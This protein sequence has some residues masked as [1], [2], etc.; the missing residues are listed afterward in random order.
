MTH[1]IPR[2]L[3]KH[4]EWTP[5]QEPTTHSQSVPIMTPFQ[6]ISQYSIDDILKGK[7]FFSEEKDGAKYIGLPIALTQALEYATFDGIVATMP[8]LISAKI[9]AD[10]S[11]DFWQKWYSVHTEENIGIDKKGLF[12][13]KNEPVLV[14]VNGGGI[15]TPERIKQAYTEGL[16]DNSAKYTDTEFNDLLEGKL[17]SGITIP[18]YNFEDIKTGKS[19]LPHQ[20]GVVMPYSIA[21]GTSSGY[22]QKEAFL[23]NPLVIAR[24][25]GVLDQL[26]AY[27]KLAK[28][29]D[30]DLGNYHPFSG[31]DATTSQ[32]RLLYL[33]NYYDGLN[34]SYNLNNDGRFVGV[35]PEAQGKKKI[36]GLNS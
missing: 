23:E 15:L 19:G 16:I 4:L 18:L 30:N 6:N 5:G 31:R 9:K 20:F 22:H 27:Y 17:P 8:E 25:A 35:A 7:T 36:E 21:Q 32:G 2:N 3:I 34:G 12:Y 1:I 10:K 14:I 13:K 29:D 11:H 24:A 28:A 33:S 26:E